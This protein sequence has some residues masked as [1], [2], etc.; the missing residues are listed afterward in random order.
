[1]R[2]ESILPVLYA[3]ASTKKTK[4]WEVRVI[5]DDDG[6]HAGIAQLITKWGYVGQK[7]DKIQTTVRLIKSGKNLGKANATGVF[8]QALLEAQ[9]DWNKKVDK[10]YTTDPSGK[11][12]ALL[13]MLA[14]DYF[15][16]KHDVKW[17]CLVQP[18]LNGVRLLARK[19]EQG[20]MEFISRGGKRFET[21]NHLSGIL[22]AGLNL[23]ETLDGELY[24]HGM[25]LQDIVSIV[26]R[27]KEEHPDRLR[28]Q[29][30]VYDLVAPDKIFSARYKEYISRF[31]TFLT[32]QDLVKPVRAIEVANEEELRQIH[33]YFVEQG[34]EGTIIRNMDG[35][36]R[37]DFRSPD[38]QKYKDFQDAEFLVI[39]GREGE[40]KDTG[41]ITW[42]CITQE[43]KP[44]DVRPRGTDAQRKEWFKNREQYFGKH[45]TVRF[46]NY[47]DDGIPIFPVGIVFRDYE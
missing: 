31:D 37:C 9:S 13:P 6:E 26:K 11:V 2:Q 18:K 47:S 44:F 17:P 34:F 12:N 3:Q 7:E 33:K 24:I 10:K 25:S 27:A 46:Q 39:G 28:L 22:S 5:L 42:Q 35:L 40:G 32:D 36:Y 43:G 21:L 20:E 45:L 41:K 19:N 1:M 29:Y 16:R 23:N 30:W 4:W 38:L 8:E 15:K 14:Q